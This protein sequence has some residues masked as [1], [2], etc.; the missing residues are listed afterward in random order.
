MARPA[1]KSPVAA[2]IAAPS[3]A[4]NIVPTAAPLT[5]VWLALSTGSPPTCWLA[6]CRQTASSDW[7]TSKGFSGPGHTMTLGP[8]GIVAQALNATKANSKRKIP[9]MFMLAYPLLLAGRGYF[10]FHLYPTA[11]TTFNVRVVALRILAVIP[12][13]RLLLRRFAIRRRGLSYSRWIVGPAYITP[14][15]IEGIRPACIRPSQYRK[16]PIK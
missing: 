1:P 11:R 9:F 8:V 12:I 10:R 2:P 15:P 5:R 13:V 16:S 14:S 3:P 4:P 7:N 6:H